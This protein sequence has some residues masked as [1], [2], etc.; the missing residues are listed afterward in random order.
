MKFLS[1]QVIEL[2]TFLKGQHF[3]N[4]PHLWLSVQFKQLLISYT[5]SKVLKITQWK[6][7]KKNFWVKEYWDPFFAEII[8]LKTKQKPSSCQLSISL[9]ILIRSR[10]FTSKSSKEK[11]IEFS[12]LFKL[13]LKTPVLLGWKILLGVGHRGATLLGRRGGG[14]AWGP[15]GRNWGEC[16]VWGHGQAQNGGRCEGNSSMASEAS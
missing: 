12:Y 8:L 9:Q 4:T 11:R 13:F 2:Q 1:K 10:F 6:Q 7:K 3:W 16:G 15:G 5:N 14:L